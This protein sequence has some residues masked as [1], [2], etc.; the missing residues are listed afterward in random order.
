MRSLNFNRPRVCSGKLLYS[1]VLVEILEILGKAEVDQL[2][3]RLS[4]VE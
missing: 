1:V 2:F 4:F 3:S